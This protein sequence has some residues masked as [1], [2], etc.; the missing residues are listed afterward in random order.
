MERVCFTAQVDPDR[1][2]EY[3]RWHEQ[4]WPEMLAAL[5]DSGWR[6]YWLWLRDDGLLVG[7]VLTDDLSALQEAMSSRD[8]NDRW[9][10]EMAEFFA[11]NDDRRPDDQFQTLSTV[12]HLES[13]LEAAGMSTSPP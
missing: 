10:A 5:R 7:T 6:D 9:Q 8:V 2:D 4:V 3:R 12:F 1:L 11:S 13:Q